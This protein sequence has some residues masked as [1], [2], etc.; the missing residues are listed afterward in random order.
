[1]GGRTLEIYIEYDLFD[2]RSEH[3]TKWFTGW[4]SM[5]GMQ[6][7]CREV[8]CGGC[9]WYQ[10]SEDVALGV[11]KV[12][13]EGSV[14]MYDFALLLGIDLVR[15]MRSC[16]MGVRVAVCEGSECVDMNVKDLEKWYEE[17]VWGA[18][19]KL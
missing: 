16:P 14:S 9:T 10:C 19:V 13:I 2:N 17:L 18:E 11:I 12:S 3:F 6:P 5:W 1:M 7:R 4:L 8:R 15:L